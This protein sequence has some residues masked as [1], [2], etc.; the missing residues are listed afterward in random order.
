MMEFRYI[1][2]NFRHVRVKLVRM[3]ALIFS[4]VFILAGI[5]PF[6]W[7]GD[8]HWGKLV[9]QLTVILIIAI[10]VIRNSVRSQRKIFKS[11]RLLIDDE[12]ILLQR[13]GLKDLVIAQ[14]EVRSIVRKQNGNLIVKGKNPHYTI[15]ILPYIDNQSE[16]EHRLNEI[17]AIRHTRGNANGLWFLPISLLTAAAIAGIGMSYDKVIR[18]ICI[19][20]LMVIM[21]AGFYVSQ[22]HK[23]TDP[24]TRVLSWA[25]FIPLL[26]FVCYMLLR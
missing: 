15:Y 10:V 26:A 23:N 12:K 25:I 5:L 13:Q 17:S 11:F 19:G 20:L 22:V 14:S 18:F 8:V 9:I 3:L 6:V 1:P 2:E 21:G 24:T 7:S 4:G 16:L